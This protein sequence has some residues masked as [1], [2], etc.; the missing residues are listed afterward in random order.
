MASDDHRVQAAAGSAGEGGQIRLI[1]SV[2][3]ASILLRAPASL[4]TA[5]AARLA[6]LGAVASGRAERVVDLVVLAG[7]EEPRAT[8]AR[9]ATDPFT[10]AAAI[11]VVSLG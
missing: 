2:T 4:A 10:S 6:A 7:E 1:G 8:I 11:L 3:T 5:L 9:L